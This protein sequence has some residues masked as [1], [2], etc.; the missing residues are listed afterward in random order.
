MA[1]TGCAATRDYRPPL[2]VLRALGLGD[3]LTIVPA[4]RALH[5]AYRDHRVVLACPAWLHPLARVSGAVDETLDVAGLDLFRTR[6]PPALAVNLHGRGPRSHRVLLALRPL[7]L[8][9][10]RR[11][12]IR[13]SEGMPE[14]RDGEHEV[15]RWCRLMVETGIACDPDDLDLDAA[16]LRPHAPAAAVGATL[17]H[18]GAASGSRRWPVERFAA[19]ARAERARGRDV[20]VTGGPADAARGAAIARQAQLPRSAVLAGGTDLLALA[21]AVAVA[22]RVVSGDTGV[23]HLATALRR[24]SVLLFGPVPPHEWGPP[25]RALHRVLW[26]GSRGDPH[27]DACDPGLLRIGV[28]D[29]VEALGALPDGAV[30]TPHN[31]R[32]PFAQRNAG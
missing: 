9:A 3:L 7:S 1:L 19:V 23:G 24:P 14:W 2:L 32:A 22:A 4:L 6:L 8:L 13:E 29:V 5:R 11:P 27:A 15:T 17:M 28:D 21:G 10:Y 25:P 30:Q 12:E 20:V 16:R 26:A 31:G 18:P